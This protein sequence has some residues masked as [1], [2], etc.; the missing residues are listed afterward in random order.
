MLWL[1]DCLNVDGERFFFAVSKS[2]KCTQ[3]L[4]IVLARSYILP[5]HCS[6]FCDC[7][8]TCPVTLR[9]WQMGYIT[10][11]CPRLLGLVSARKWGKERGSTPT[12]LSHLRE[13]GLKDEI[14][15]HTSVA[16]LH[17]SIN[18]PA[19]GQNWSVSL[20]EEV[21]VRVRAKGMIRM[22]HPQWSIFP[23]NSLLQNT[24][25]VLIDVVMSLWCWIL[26]HKISQSHGH[27]AEDVHLLWICLWNVE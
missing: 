10:W 17:Y 5:L 9:D 4:I 25:S 22:H 1:W 23:W 2:S 15:Q 27:C 24:V 11:C 26:T 13:F 18:R 21:H 8:P 16:E 7:T 20:R 14:L 19:G 6:A 12:P 3:H